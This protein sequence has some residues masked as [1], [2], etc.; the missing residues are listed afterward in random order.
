MEFQPALAVPDPAAPD[1]SATPD[2]RTTF[3][4]ES[5][6]EEWNQAMIVMYT[7]AQE[8]RCWPL[9]RK[10]PL[11]IGRSEHCDIVLDD[12]QVSRYHARITWMD[13]Y[14][15]IEDL[16]SKNGTQVNGKA[17]TNSV[18]LQDGDELQVGPHSNLVF[19]DDGATT[20]LTIAPHQRG[21]SIDKDTR[22]VWVN[23]TQLD[24][25]LSLP[26][27][28]LIVKLWESE[29]KIVSRD[30][31]VDTVWPEE[32]FE[33]ISEQAIDAL[34]RRLRERIA[35]VDPD[36]QYVVTVRGHGFRLENR[37]DQRSR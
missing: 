7:A 28:Q 36:G 23:Q 37:C 16:G 11:T 4:K 25:P 32:S 10:R 29:G 31:I 22:T 35:E 20:P 26:Q 34:I 2:N 24:P 14:Y 27:Y 30:E 6:H 3:Q 9:T 13:D 5:S 19:V 1:F 18:I 12:R 15:C 17:Y 33:G 8:R 21:L